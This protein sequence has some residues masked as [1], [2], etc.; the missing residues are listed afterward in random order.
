MRCHHGVATTRRSRYCKDGCLKSH[1]KHGDKGDQ[2]SPAAR[3]SRTITRRDRGRTV[4]S[5]ARPERIEL[6]RTEK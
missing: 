2:V 4:R 6:A 5:V 3:H 1:G